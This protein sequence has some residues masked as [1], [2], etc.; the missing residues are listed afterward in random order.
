MSW[1]IDIID[2]VS[3][4]SLDLL[5]RITG[6]AI[7][8]YLPL[9]TV[10]FYH[11]TNIRYSGNV[12]NDIDGQRPQTVFFSKRCDVESTDNLLWVATVRCRDVYI[13]SLRGASIRSTLSF[14]SCFSFNYFW[15]TVRCL[16]RGNSFINILHFLRVVRSKKILSVDLILKSTLFYFQI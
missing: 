11:G 14:K 13:L 3:I 1:C 6:E 10:L 12:R 15:I 9:M 8:P 4:G 16:L 2:G 5:Y 7:C